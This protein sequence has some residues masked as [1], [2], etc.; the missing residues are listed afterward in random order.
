MSDAADSRLGAAACNLVAA[1]GGRSA[2]PSSDAPPVYPVNVLR[3]SPNEDCME[4]DAS[5]VL[6]SQWT[7]VAAPSALS[8]LLAEFNAAVQQFRSELKGEVG[9][10]YDGSTGG[11]SELL[12]LGE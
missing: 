12:D 8:A 11:I 9:K 7:G 3:L 6:D 5:S 1:L 10:F 4:L 2:A